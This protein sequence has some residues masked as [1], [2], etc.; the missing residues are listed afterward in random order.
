MIFTL[1]RDE[2]GKLRRRNGVMFCSPYGS[3]TFDDSTTPSTLKTV[4]KYYLIYGH[5]KDEI[6]QLFFFHG[7]LIN[8]KGEVILKGPR[9]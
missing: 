3:M 6:P 9:P 1:Y 4:T 8:L 2:Y 5:H 7:D